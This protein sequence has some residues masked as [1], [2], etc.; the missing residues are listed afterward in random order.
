MFSEEE[1]ARAENA[2][3]SVRDDWLQRPG[4]TAVDLGFKWSKGLMTE[5]LAIR[6]HLT[7]KKPL[8]EVDAQERFPSEID[9]IL[10]D[11]IEANYTIQQDTPKRPTIAVE[12]RRKPLNEIPLGVSIGTRHSTAGTLGAKV[13]DRQTNQEMI[14]GNW[15]VMVATLAPVPHLPIWQPG[16]IDGGDNKQAIAQLSRH[17]LGPYDAA[18]GLITGQRPITTQTIEGNPIEDAMIPT[19]GM[20][21]WKSGRT[22]GYTKGVID[23]L[24]M[25]VPINYRVAGSRMMEDVFR[26]VPRRG[27][28]NQEIS[29]GGDSGS[30]WVDEATGKAVGLH[31]AGESGDA[32]EHALAHEIIAVLQKLNVRLPAQ[33]IPEP[34][35]DP[36]SSIFHR[37]WQAIGRFLDSF[38]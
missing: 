4:V 38:T 27:H 10:V 3:N 11:V 19:L 23:G 31:F 33:V 28:E 37:I 32:K 35:P 14:L 25:S 15:H 21:V 12:E 24:K 17:I 13:I 36:P 8:E 30:V 34:A 20:Q 5:L 18:V 1:M 22:T 26:I 29:K 7:R 16:R 9:G 2:L 6:V